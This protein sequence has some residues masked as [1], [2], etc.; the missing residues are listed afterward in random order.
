MS[1]FID[2]ITKRVVYKERVSLLLT[3]SIFFVGDNLDSS[4][5]VCTLPLSLVLFYHPSF[6]VFRDTSSLY[7]PVSNYLHLSTYPPLPK[8][9][10]RR[11]P[12]PWIRHCTLTYEL[13]L[14]PRLN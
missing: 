14:I 5:H 3:Y 13:R 11:L 4:L 6:M 9:P 7:K 8:L 12:S 2:Y 10:S 1:L